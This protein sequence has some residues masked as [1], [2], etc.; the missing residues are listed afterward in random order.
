MEEEFK[1]IIIVDSY[2]YSHFYII[3]VRV[4]V[5]TKIKSRKKQNFSNI[6]YVM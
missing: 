3:L 1:L 6:K 2:P 4:S 5:K